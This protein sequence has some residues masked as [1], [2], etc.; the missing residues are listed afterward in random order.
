MFWA[1]LEG[2]G[3]IIERLDYWHQRT[4]KDV[5]Q[6]APLLKR[7]AETGSWEGGTTA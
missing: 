6:V 5:F 1:G 2:A 4:G 7:M 3:K